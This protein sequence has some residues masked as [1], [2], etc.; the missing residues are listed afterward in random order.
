MKKKEFRLHR[1]NLEF[2]Y[3]YVYQKDAEKQVNRYEGVV[4]FRNAEQEYFTLKVDK[5]LSF[6]IIKIINQK[7]AENT[8]TLVNN[9]KSAIKNE[10]DK[11]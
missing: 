6:Q 5:E 9:I 2:K 10:N 8:E 7:L 3:G 1:F 11:I 4:T